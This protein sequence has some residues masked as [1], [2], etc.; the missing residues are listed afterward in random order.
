[1]VIVSLP[2]VKFKSVAIHVHLYVTGIGLTTTS[3]VHVFPS[4]SSYCISPPNVHA[5]LIFRL[6]GPAGGL[7]SHVRIIFRP[8]HTVS[9]CGSGDAVILT[10]KFSPRLPTVPTYAGIKTNTFMTSPLMMID[11]CITYLLI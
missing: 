1:M 5:Q 3:I 11:I 7:V 6:D 10:D 8:M 9:N 2:K 4:M